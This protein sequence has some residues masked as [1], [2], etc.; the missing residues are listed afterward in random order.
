[1]AAIV[2]ASLPEA[3]AALEAARL[4]GVA[5]EIAVSAPTWRTRRWSRASI[6][7]GSGD[8]QTP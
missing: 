6:A 4:S 7:S 3:R 1:M 8:T 2:I 5:A